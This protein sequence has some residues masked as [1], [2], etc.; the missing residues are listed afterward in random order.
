MAV[1]KPTLC[2]IGAGAAGIA[3]ATRA[4]REGAKVVMVERHKL[5]GESLHYGCVPSKAL[6]ATAHANE[7]L[8]NTALFGIRVGGPTFLSYDNIFNHLMGTIDACSLERSLEYLQDL[9]ITV[10]MGRAQFANPRMLQV[11][12]IDIQANHFV[13]AT[14]S[15]PSVPAVDGLKDIPFLTNENVF[16]LTE[17]PRHLV[18]IGG[19]GVGTELCQAFRLLGSEVTLI[20]QGRLLSQEDPSLTGI[21]RDRLQS[22]GVRVIE[23]ARVQRFGGEG[24]QL[25]VELL[26]NGSPEI[27]THSHVL[28]AVG[29]TPR[30]ASLHPE[31]GGIICQARGIKVDAYLRTSNRRIFALGDCI[32]QPYYSHA[33]RYEADV[34]VDNALHGKRRTVDYSQ[35]PR[36]LFTRPGFAAVGLSE[37]DARKRHNDVQVWAAGFPENDRARTLK[38]PF[39]QIKVVARK[40]GTVLGVGIVGPDAGEL[41][42]P[43]QLAIANKIK[44]PAIADIMAPYPTLS[45]LSVSVARQYVAAK[46]QPGLLTRLLSRAPK[47][48]AA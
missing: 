19:G 20:T 27:L 30:F 31:V 33:S 32:G 1:L 21:I 23:H 18:I 41:L 47:N 42:L 16:S 48:H 24:T 17:R 11:G 46:R 13:L 5:G 45:E 9:G 25:S 8:G 10:L 26:V 15:R 3:V 43:W 7:A 37:R 28:L 14:G 6:L 39:G 38:E 12:E 4:A 29:R 34:V 2:V 22:Q 35:V 40:D 44:L 36:V